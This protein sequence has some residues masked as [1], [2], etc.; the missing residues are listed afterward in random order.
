MSIADKVLQL[1][2]DIDDAYQAGYNKGAAEGG[3]TEDAYN[4]G[5]ESGYH[6]GLSDID[7]ET[8]ASKFWDGVIAS[9]EAKSYAY[10]YSGPGWNDFN[11]IPTT[12]FVAKARGAL[13][14]MF[15]GLN[16]IK[17]SMEK[18]NSKD[19]FGNQTC[20]PY[21]NYMFYNN[22]NLKEIYFDL[23]GFQELGRAFA[24]CGAQKITLK[25]SW[26]GFDN[27]F[28]S[29]SKLEDLTFLKTNSDGEDEIRENFI[30]M[31]SF[32][33]GSSPLNKQSI[34]GVIKGLSA[35]TSGLKVTFKR[36]AVINAFELEVD[37]ETGEFISSEKLDEWNALVATKSN[38]TISLA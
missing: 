35:G 5:Y 23:K 15:A 30:N 14:Y 20:N 19:Y 36:T 25:N 33:L 29:C 7:G 11:S 13:T 12:K 3:N 2:Q 18:F 38:W 26:G 9:C 22:P 1:K 6:D 31:Y 27:T 28:N 37:S 16:S 8:Y 34:I 21:I 17:N 4:E 32:T 10:L 24:G